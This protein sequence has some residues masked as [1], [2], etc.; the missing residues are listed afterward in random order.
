MPHRGCASDLGI[1]IVADL[2]PG[3]AECKRQRHEPLLGTIVEVSF[4]P[5]PFGIARLD[6]PRPRLPDLA[7]LGLD[8]GLQ[9]IVLDRQPDGAGHRRN[10]RGIVEQDL[11][12]EDGRDRLA[13]A[14][15]EG[16]RPTRVGGRQDRRRAVRVEVVGGFRGPV[17]DRQAAIA[18]RVCQCVPE[19]GRGRHL[20]QL[21]DEVGDRRASH[22]R[23]EQ[24]DKE[25]DR[26]Q[27]PGQR[28]REAGDQPDVFGDVEG[29]QEIRHTGSR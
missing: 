13:V 9:A 8:L 10:E 18:Q 11:V 14:L 15:Q 26:D 2:E 7:E 6:D 19:P 29:A 5:L 20:A 24:T 25:S 16:H 12:V 3:E 28:L 1:P 22:P 23:A 21:D 27:G 4:D 17:R